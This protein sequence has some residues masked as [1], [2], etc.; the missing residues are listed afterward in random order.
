MDDLIK[1]TKELETLTI[2]IDDVFKQ[3]SKIIKKI[4]HLHLLELEIKTKIVN[5]KKLKKE[6]ENWLLKKENYIIWLIRLGVQITRLKKNKINITD[7]N[8]TKLKNLI[9]FL[10]KYNT[11]KNEVTN[12]SLT[13][14]IEKQINELYQSIFNTNKNLINTKEEIEDIIP[15]FHY[16]EKK[17]EISFT[18]TIK[19]NLKTKLYKTKDFINPQTIYYS[20]AIK[21]NITAFKLLLKGE[22]KIA[23]NND[24]LLAYLKQDAKIVGYQIKCQKIIE[25]WVSKNDVKIF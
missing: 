22:E 15:L 25:G 5:D 21:R 9:R 23:Y 1:T 12:K 4:E 14:K 7:E 16:E 2:N 6:Y 13:Q 19:V 20:P 17:S 3:Y 11:I 10:T 8:Q 24:E 18:N